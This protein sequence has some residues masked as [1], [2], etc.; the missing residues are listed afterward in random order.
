MQ[1]TEIIRNNDGTYSLRVYA[2]V[3]ITGTLDECR[4]REQL[5]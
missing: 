4:A 3:V 1:P 5:E 2:T